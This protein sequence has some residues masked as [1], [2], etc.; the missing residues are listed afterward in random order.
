MNSLQYNRETKI[1][2]SRV[3]CSFLDEDI[4]QRL[5]PSKIGIRPKFT[6]KGTVGCIYIHVFSP[7][8]SLRRFRLSLDNWYIPTRI[9]NLFKMLFLTIGPEFKADVLQLHRR[10][11]ETN[12]V[13]LCLTQSQLKEFRQYSMETSCAFHDIRRTLLKV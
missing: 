11:I 9:Q 3:I 7:Q 10:Y 13:L 12:N 4:S 6:K 8:Y 5:Y 1:A 2:L